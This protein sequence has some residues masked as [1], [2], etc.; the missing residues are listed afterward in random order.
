MIDVYVDHPGAARAD[1]E[2]AVLAITGRYI[3]EADPRGFLRL[4]LRLPER[5]IGVVMAALIA[6][7]WTVALE[8]ESL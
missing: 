2:S 8:G 3:S 1:V 6:E 7:G 4:R 5:H